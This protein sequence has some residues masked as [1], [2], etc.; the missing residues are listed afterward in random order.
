MDFTKKMPWNSQDLVNLYNDTASGHFFDR[1]TMRFFKSRVTDNFRRLSDTEA[2]FITTERGPSIGSKRLATVRKAVIKNIR[3]EDGALVS[4]VEIDTL[5]EFNAL[6]L[7][8]AKNVL[9]NL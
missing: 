7:Y 4:K 6:S 5:G 8:K 1:E 2:V 9:K 3:R